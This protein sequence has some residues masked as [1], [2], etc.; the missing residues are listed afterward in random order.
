[1]AD[2]V[3]R[4]TDDLIGI[5]EAI[6]DS[7]QTLTRLTKGN[8]ARKPPSNRAHARPRGA[9]LIRKFCV[10][11]SISQAKNIVHRNPRRGFLTRDYPLIARV[12]LATWLSTL[13]A[14]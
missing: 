5:A 3:G 1:M 8:R 13:R 2:L 9:W 10:F 14:T 11:S 6:P 7:P 4:E 12:D